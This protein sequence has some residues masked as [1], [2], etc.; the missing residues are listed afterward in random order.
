MANNNLFY[1]LYSHENNYVDVGYTC[2][3]ALDESQTSFDISDD[4]GVISD[5][6]GD[7]LASIDLSDIHVNP[8]TNYSSDTKVLNPGGNYILHGPENGDSYGSQEFIIPSPENP[9]DPNSD[10]ASHPNWPQHT[11]V[12]I[13]LTYNGIPVS[14][15]T[16]K[17][18]R[19]LENPESVTDILQKIFDC[20]QIPLVA[21]AIDS[22]CASKNCNCECDDTEV[23][24]VLKIQSEELGFPFSVESVKITPILQSESNVNSPFNVPEVE[25][26]DVE[27]LVTAYEDIKALIE[28]DDNYSL[29]DFFQFVYDNQ[30]DGFKNIT[31]EDPENY[32]AYS[33]FKN[34]LTNE[35]LIS[36]KR[37]QEFWHDLAVMKGFNDE[38]MY[39]PHHYEMKEMECSKVNSKKYPN[40]AMQGLIIVPQFPDGVDESDLKSLKL[41]YLKDNVNVYSAIDCSCGDSQHYVKES[42]EVSTTSNGSNVSVVA[43]DCSTYC[44][45][46][47]NNG[48]CAEIL[49]CVTEKKDTK[50]EE[51]KKMNLQKFL[52]FATENDLWIKF[53]PLFAVISNADDDN[54]NE[55]NLIP[56][57]FINNPNNI[58]IKVNFMVFS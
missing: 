37:L 41:V 30:E 39:V 53:G 24:K 56:S 55:K 3:S 2:D 6:N 11:D 25:Y 16:S 52:D 45:G 28:N 17:F 36:A 7:P 14:I 43:S 19:D 48:K 32:I 57:V 18:N 29:A 51:K 23:H 33:Y 26:K 42:L 58:P 15:D 12:S 10:I 13:D 44:K 47:C 49:Q 4:K 54:N 38:G 20:L 1:Q 40:G 8:V 34:I 21:S 35:Y 31:K 46:K 9:S 22:S 27:T 5:S 50:Q